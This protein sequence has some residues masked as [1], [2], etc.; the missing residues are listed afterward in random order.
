MP[1]GAKPALQLP[2]NVKIPVAP[3]WVNAWTVIGWKPVPLWLSE[4]VP[5]GDPPT[6]TSVSVTVRVVG[7]QV[8]HVTVP[9]HVPE[10]D[11]TVR[12][13]CATCAAGLWPSFA[14]S[15]TVKRPAVAYVFVVVAPAAVVPSPRS[16]VSVSVSPSGSVTPAGVSEK[17]VAACRPAA[18]GAGV[19]VPLVGG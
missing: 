4:H 2:V 18:A 10:S 13:T 7:V 1:N 9:L 14:V 8:P 12:L 19:M 16:Q 6:C 11:R 3:F 15:L 5:L 17:T